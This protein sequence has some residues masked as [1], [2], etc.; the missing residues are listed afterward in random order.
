MVSKALKLNSSVQN[1][2]P[3]PVT[4]TS[5]PSKALDINSSPTRQSSRPS[6]IV[7]RRAPISASTPIPVVIAKSLPAKAFINTTI[8][9]PPVISN[10]DTPLNRVASPVGEA[11]RKG[12]GGMSELIARYQSQS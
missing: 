11:E 4:Q 5:S 9:K 6:P 1:T 3:R 10:N 2:P 12:K 7:N 8:G